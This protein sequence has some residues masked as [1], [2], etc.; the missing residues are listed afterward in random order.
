MSELAVL[1]VVVTTG[2]LITSLTGLGGGSLILAVLLLMF[3][4]QLAIPLHTFTQVSANVLRTGIGFKSVNWKVVG[5]YGALMIPATWIAG[6]LFDHINSSWL[7]IVVG[8]FLLISVLPLRF[9]PKGETRLG[10]FVILGA[11]SG[12]LGVFVGSVGPMVTPFFNRLRIG[13]EGVLTTKSAG[14]MVMQFAK[15]IAFSGAAQ[16][17]FSALQNYVWIL[18]GASLA[19]VLISLPIGKKISDE[20]LD[21]AV[22][23]LLGLISVKILYEGVTELLSA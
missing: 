22:N 18:I 2:A 3:P 15:L 9:K 10:T 13:R 7:K 21:L 4:P 19:G 8:A 5:A 16:I 11:I 20:K 23:I 6:L 1:F 14:Q 12:F 17:D